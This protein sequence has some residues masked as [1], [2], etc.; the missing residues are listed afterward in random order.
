MWI[1]DLAPRLNLFMVSDDRLYK[2]CFRGVSDPT[3]RWGQ[4]HMPPDPFRKVCAPADRVKR[5]AGEPAMAKDVRKLRG[6]ACY[7]SKKGAWQ[8]S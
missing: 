8:G 3:P 5:R 6:L 1:P 2:A 4:L 7:G